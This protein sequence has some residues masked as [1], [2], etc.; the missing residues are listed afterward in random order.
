MDDIHVQKTERFRRNKVI[1]ENVEFDETMLLTMS[2][3]N[4]LSNE[5]NKKRIISILIQKFADESIAVEQTA[6]DADRTIVKR[7]IEHAHSESVIAVEEYIGILVILTALAP[8]S[9]QLFLIKPRKVK[10][11]TV[12][13]SSIHLKISSK[14]KENILFLQAFSGYDSSSAIFRHGK[15][16][17]VKFLE[18]DA[19][20]FIQTI[21]E[22]FF[23]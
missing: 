23:K 11:E 10:F 4:F 22:I 21:V 13:Y 15:M 18:K 9:D 19:E 2:T 12:F 17:R 5:G 7:A 14:V 6:E 3:D 20:I 16:K 8:N 1:A